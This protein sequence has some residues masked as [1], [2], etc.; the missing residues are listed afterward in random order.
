MYWN[1][2]AQELY[3]W[4]AV[5]AIGR[6]PSELLQTKYPEMLK[7][8]EATVLATGRWEGELIHI[9]KDETQVAVMSHWSLRQ[10]NREPTAVIEL[11]IPIEAVK[12]SSSAIKSA[13]NGE[14]MGGLT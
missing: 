5:E 8:I 7:S 9:K 13:S 6:T 1:R 11:N 2:G 10:S 14:M 3:G 12:P 4:N